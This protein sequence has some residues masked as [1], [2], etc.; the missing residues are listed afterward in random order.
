MDLRYRLTVGITGR[1]IMASKLAKSTTFTP[2]VGQRGGPVP[3]VT[4]RSRSSGTT[5][6]PRRGRRILI[7]HSP[8]RARDE[9]KHLSQ[10]TTH[11]TEP[12]RI[13]RLSANR[14]PR[15]T[16]PVR[17]VALIALLAV[18]VGVNP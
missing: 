15:P 4:S 13:E 2:T 12:F 5:R 9:E 7:E 3:V 16:V 10:Q 6:S 17:G 14:L 8:I 18:Q 1:W 11:D